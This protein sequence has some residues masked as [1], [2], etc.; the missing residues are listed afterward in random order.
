V[1]ALTEHQRQALEAYRALTVSHP[2]LFEGRASRPIVLDPDV[3]AAYASE[4]GAVLGVAADTPYVLFIV[5]LV[6]DGRSVRYPYLRV[7]SRA[8][9]NGAVNVVVIAT[10]E[11]PSLGRPG[12]IVF[13]EQERHAPGS[14]E[15]EL[16]RG[17]G[18]AGLTGEQNALRELQEETGYVG[19]QAHLL[20]STLTDSGLTDCLVSFYHVP[21]T[22]R[23]AS[24]PEAAELI[25]SVSLLSRDQAWD[26]IRSGELRDAF[27]VQA[28]ALLENAAGR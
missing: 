23:V 8:Q 6:E 24:S 17:F 1:T 21:V 27:T 4:H 3:L 9:L 22:Q 14:R 5:D 10:L 18:E 19:Q 28:L 20:G 11:D 2:K 7:V 12:D 25:R 15:L 13:V 26:R 16:P